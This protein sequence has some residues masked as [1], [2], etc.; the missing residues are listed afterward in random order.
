MARTKA[1]RASVDD[2]LVALDALPAKADQRRDALAHA[3]EHRSSRVVAKA[4]RLAE[5]A[6]AYE[7][8]PQLL[9]AWPR[10]LDKPAKTD[11]GCIA[12]KALARALV[13]LDCSDT[14]FF[15]RGLACRQPE[16]VWGGT[17]DTA[18]DVRASCAMGLVATGY[19]R[20]LVELTA[21]MHD[22]EPAARAGAVRAV[23]CGNPKDAELLL[24]LKLASGD[25][26]PSVL[27]ECFTAL[28]AVAP[29]ESVPHVA[30]HL[31]A[32]D[33]TVRELAAL[34][35]GESRLPAAY[36]PL[37]VAWQQPLQSRGVRRALL[38][39]AVAH[40]SEAAQQWLLTLVGES[41]VETALE[42][43]E[44]LA[45]YRHNAALASRLEATVAERAEPALAVRY[46]EL[47]REGA[48]AKP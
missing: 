8:V 34:A 40:R 27:G 17:V 19:S 39:A 44:A 41:R 35:L 36:E 10:F 31:D 23:A 26:A 13:A 20:A 48:K 28:L 9:T 46:A 22:S 7:L 29:E 18:V 4:A 6:L 38:R 25:A 16:P 3:L 32:A 43:V 5:D 1:S 14:D 37:L 21:L 47:W 24:R 2:V 42:V 12:R 15:L 33:E 45:L 11:P 30:K